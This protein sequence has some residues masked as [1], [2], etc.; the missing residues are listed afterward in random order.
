MINFIHRCRRFLRLSKRLLLKTCVI[1]SNL[2]IAYL[3]VLCVFLIAFSALPA[4][5]QAVRLTNVQHLFDIT[6]SFKQ[7]SDVA[8]SKEG[9]IYVVDGVNSAVKVFNQ[10]GKFIFSFGAKGP[11]EGEFKFPL[12]IGIDSAGRVYV[13]DSGNHRVQIFNST[14]GFLS[15]IRVLSK[16]GR[17]ADPTDV[18]ID[19]SAGKI[20][21]VD[22]DNHCIHAYDRATLQK[23]ESYGAPGEGDREFRYPFLMALDAE[24]YLYIVDVINTRVQILS[25]EGLYVA[26]VGKWG[27]EK[28]EFFRPKGVAIDRNGKIYVSDSYMGVV[29][30]FEPVGDFYSA[31][32]DPDKGAVR[33]F[34]TPAGIFIDNKDRLYV[35]EMFAEKVSV[36]QLEKDAE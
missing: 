36:Y 18:S 16:N 11:A 19:E 17:P 3:C 24:R 10:N 13:A 32:G 7:P 20:Y 6:Y 2:R 14:G 4:P 5:A 28:G 23:I 22:N 31:I 21:I 9:L 27:V 30:V 25:P 29:Q 1:L 33:K 34:V 35:V 8:V 15:Q 26:S 12:G